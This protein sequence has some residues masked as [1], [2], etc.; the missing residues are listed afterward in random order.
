MTPLKR[1]FYSLTSALASMA[2]MA[3]SPQDPIVIVP[4]RVEPA[5]DD[6]SSRLGYFHMTGGGKIT[7]QKTI[8]FAETEG[9]EGSADAESYD[10]RT[11][12]KTAVYYCGVLLKAPD[13]D[14]QMN[15]LDA[16]RE[17]WGVKRRRYEIRSDPYL[18]RK[19]IEERLRDPTKDPIRVSARIEYA[20]SIGGV[21]PKGAYLYTWMKDPINPEEED[22]TP[23][24]PVPD[25]AP[26]PPKEWEEARFTF[27]AKGHYYLVDL[28]TGERKRSPLR[29]N[30]VEVQPKRITPDG[31]YGLLWNGPYAVL[32]DLKTSEV[33]KKF[34]AGGWFRDA[35]FSHDSKLMATKGQ[36]LRVWDIATGKQLGLIV[37]NS[38]GE[39]VKGL[40]GGM[41]SPGYKVGKGFPKNPMTF[42]EIS[43][44]GRFVW[45][46]YVDREPD[47]ASE[48]QHH[49]NIYAIWDWKS[50]QWV[51]A[52]GPCCAKYPK[53]QFCPGSGSSQLRCGLTPSQLER[54]EGWGPSDDLVFL[55]GDTDDHVALVDLPTGKVI[56]KLMLPPGSAK[57]WY[58]PIWSA[59]L[60]QT[61]FWASDGMALS[62]FRD[63][64]GA[65]RLIRWDL[66]PH[67][68]EIKKRAALLS[69]KP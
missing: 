57:R 64:K 46:Y 9:G 12:E 52:I 37:F 27:L 66:G 65:V 44:S 40:F 59:V 4:S 41:P 29:Y 6:R 60:G 45:F 35:Y 16:E 23:P 24:L 17:R 49:R 39:R 22:R 61:L 21:D 19:E 26:P 63:D 54:F 31:R 32:L 50:D 15:V 10:L 1:F 3:Q 51:G 53:T 20:G 43:P 8:I 30:G 13:L 56:A 28:T 68:E 7:P 2:S 33:Y 36:G 18:S 47:P 5:S 38:L 58:E 25:W 55:T 62:D 42:C 11:L 14:K 48:W 67:L 34:E 69:G